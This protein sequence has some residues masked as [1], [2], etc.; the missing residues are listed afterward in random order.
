MVFILLSGNAYAGKKLDCKYFDSH[1]EA[2]TETTTTYL[3]E[4]K[5]P[6]KYIT[7]LLDMENKKIIRTYSPDTYGFAGSKQK[8]TDGHISWFNK[9][10]LKNEKK[11]IRVDGTL[12]RYTGKYV[13][14]KETLKYSGIPNNKENPLKVN[15]FEN[16]SITWKCEAKKKLF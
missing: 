4:V 8:W 6:L 12:Y 9:K 13:Y 11:L 16:L 5:N 1:H 2:H 7:I 14:T 15:P 10:N 3:G